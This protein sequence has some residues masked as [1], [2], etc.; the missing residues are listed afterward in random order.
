MTAP[1]AAWELEE[2]DIRGLKLKV[3]KH[4]PPS[5]RAVWLASKVSWIDIYL[6]IAS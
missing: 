5:I 3:Y 1:G 6:L 2:K 4:A